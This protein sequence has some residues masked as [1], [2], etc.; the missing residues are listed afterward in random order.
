VLAALWPEL[1]EAAAGRNLRRLRHVLGRALRE[2]G[3]DSDVVVLSGETLALAPE[4]EVDVEGFR[5][6][7]NEARAAR[8]DAGAYERAL[9]TYRGELLPD[10]RV[11]EWTEPSRAELRALRRLLLLELSDLYGTQGE[12][13]RAMEL[14]EQVLF[15]DPADEEAHRFL[16]RLHARAGR[17]ERA[18]RQYDTCREAL[19]RDLGARPEPETDALAEQIRAGRVARAAAADAVSGGFVGRAEEVARMRA[20]LDTTIAGRGQ[21][22]LLGGEA[23]IGKTRLVEELALYARVQETPLVWGRCY[24]DEGLPAFWPWVQIVRSCSRRGSGGSSGVS[25]FLEEGALGA[26][27]PSFGGRD[28]SHNCACSERS[29]ISSGTW[30]GM[31]P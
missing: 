6:A 31:S 17:R 21:V 14:I 3:I 23:G 7:A 19:E 29:A 5:A 2:G 16:M 20:A 27:S 13:T 25:S 10:D 9:A 28:P 12:Q 1:P 15:D 24:E 4:I 30:P 8:T 22:V 18:L 11:E 26:V